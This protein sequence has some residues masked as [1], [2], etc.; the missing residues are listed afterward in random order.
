MSPSVAECRRREQ[1]L[2]LWECPEVR[3]GVCVG[4][5]RVHCCV[6]GWGRGKKCAVS[7]TCLVVEFN[8][9]NLRRLNYSSCAFLF[10]R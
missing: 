8:G 3:C 2:C 7:D 6:C 9:I 4:G 10:I 5:E 1:C